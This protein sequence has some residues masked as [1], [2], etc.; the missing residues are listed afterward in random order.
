MS[1]EPITIRK[2]RPEDNE[3]IETVIRNC[4]YEYN[5]P[6]VGTAFED[7]D[8]KNMYDAYQN[9]NEVY[10]VVEQNGQVM[11]GA[12]IKPLKD[13]DGNVCELNKMY[14]S[15][16]VR[17]KGYGKLLFQKCLDAAKDLGYNQ[18]YLESGTQLKAAI[19]IYESFGFQ[20]LEGALGN[21]GH[22]SCSV[23]MIKDL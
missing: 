3:Q 22:Y 21:T 5:I 17:G 20:Y 2:I 15:K 18:C 4:F 13:C 1:I 12:G 23:W 8:I 10:F 9:S 14:F 6:L 19:H 7:P 16:E 11:G